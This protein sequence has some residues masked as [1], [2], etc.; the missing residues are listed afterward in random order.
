M[1]KPTGPAA[2]RQG[3]GYLCRHSARVLQHGIP[4]E[5]QRGERREFVAIIALHVRPRCQPLMPEPT[6][7]LDQEQELRVGDVAA[8]PL[9]DR[10]LTAGVRETVCPFNIDEVAMLQRTL[11]AVGDVGKD[12]KNEPLIVE[13]GDGDCCVTQPLRGGSAGSNCFCQHSQDPG[14]GLLFAHFQCS[15]FNP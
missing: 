14:F 4:T 1:P 13:V 15:F 2:L 8:G 11:D 12:L 6:I 10:R 5:T 7:K 9:T 3:S